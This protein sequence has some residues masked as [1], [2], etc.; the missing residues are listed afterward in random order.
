[1]ETSLCGISDR[2]LVRQLLPQPRQLELGREIF[3]EVGRADGR[4]PLQKLAG[5]SAVALRRGFGAKVEIGLAF[6]IFCAD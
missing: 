3:N 4:G 5:G 2:I 1:V 6:P